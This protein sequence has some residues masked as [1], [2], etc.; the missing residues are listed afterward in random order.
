MG[1]AS[2]PAVT[3][4]AASAG[5]RS[6]CGKSRVLLLPQLPLMRCSLYTSS[7][8][9]RPL[10]LSLYLING[11]SPTY[12]SP[13]ITADIN[14][15]ILSWYGI[16]LLSVLLIFNFKETLVGTLEQAFYYS[17]S[18]S[19]IPHTSHSSPSRPAQLLKGR[20]CS[21]LWPGRRHCSDRQVARDWVN[22]LLSTM[23]HST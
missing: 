7:H 10:P 9:A 15:I 6:S 14:L 21:I 13:I 5:K 11:I 4:T 22:C 1:I 12:P 20:F 19:E 8:R 23:C 18:S 2:S 17:S 3:C 16:W